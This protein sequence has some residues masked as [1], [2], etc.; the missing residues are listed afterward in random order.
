MNSQMPPAVV[1][2]RATVRLKWFN[3]TKGFGFVQIEDEESDA[4]LHASMFTPDQIRLLQPGTTLLC[5]LARGPRGLIASAVYEIDPS[6]ADPAADRAPA[7]HQPDVES[8]PAEDVDGTVKFYNPVK[9][10]GFLQPDDGGPDIFLPGRIM[11]QAG[12]DGVQPQER[13][14]VKARMGPRGRQAEAIE[15]LA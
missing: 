4:F 9:G 15:M 11:Q 3:Q 8:G 13:L 5:D 2:E 6:T 10:Y 1:R 7:E 12:L 14:R